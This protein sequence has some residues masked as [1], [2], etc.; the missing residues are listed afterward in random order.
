M[1][2]RHKDV[3]GMYRTGNV[4]WYYIPVPT[5]SKKRG[6][7]PSLTESRGIR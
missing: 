7:L 2:G 1:G 3:V 6:E 4:N 5:K